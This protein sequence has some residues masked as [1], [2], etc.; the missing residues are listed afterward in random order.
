[1]KLIYRAYRVELKPTQSQKVLLDKH[2]GCVR[3]IYNYFLN[4]RKE[5]YQLFNKSENYF[6]QAKLLPNLKK[7]EETS[8]LKE[9]NSQSLAESLRHLDS[10]YQKFFKGKSKFPRFKSKKGKN[11]FSVPQ[12]FKIEQN[13]LHIP[14]FKQGIKYIDKRIIN[15][16]LCNVT[17]SKTPTGRYYASILVEQEYEQKPKTG[18]FVGVDLGIKDLAVTSDGVRFKNNRYTK[19]YE[20]KLAK[21]QKHLSRKKKGSRSFENQKRKVAKI[22]EKITNTRQDVLHKITTKLIEQYD[23]I[24]VESLNVKGMMSNHNL[25]KH[26]HDASWGTFIQY[27]KYKADWNDKQVVA[28]DRYYPSSKTCNVC[29]W[30]NQNLNLSMREWTCANGHVLDRDLNAAQNILHEGLKILNSAGTVENTDGDD[31]RLSNQQL[32]TKFEI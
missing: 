6:S 28:I 16:R 1:M 9:V 25:S 5:Q 31:V 30:I 20:R 27:L 32:S 17:V 22:H 3:F 26:I 2:F 15:G 12:H 14:K 18:L 7:N 19:T 29:G 4:Q 11:S 21:A 24:V 8:W 13:R 10:A 23:T